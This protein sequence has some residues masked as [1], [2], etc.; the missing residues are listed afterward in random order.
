MRLGSH[1]RFG[2]A[3]NVMPISRRAE[4]LFVEASSNSGQVAAKFDVLGMVFLIRRVDCV[5]VGLEKPLPFPTIIDRSSFEVG[6][7]P[8]FLPTLLGLLL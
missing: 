5:A 1:R 7:T 3:E 8:A 6:L 4:Y 2:A